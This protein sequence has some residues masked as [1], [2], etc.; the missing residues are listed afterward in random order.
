VSIGSLQITA[1]VAVA[2]SEAMEMGDDKSGWLKQRDR[3]FIGGKDSSPDLVY[4]ISLST[5]CKLES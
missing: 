5:C 3:F 2:F 1:D 4:Y